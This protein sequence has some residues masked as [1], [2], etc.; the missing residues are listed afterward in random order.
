LHCELY[1]AALE[2]RI[3]AWRK[4]DAHRDVDFGISNWAPFDKGE[5]IANPEFLRNEMARMADL[6]R[7]RARKKRGS[8]PP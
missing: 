4:P 1:N 5:T 2:E 8:Y 6:Q 7:Q 3:N